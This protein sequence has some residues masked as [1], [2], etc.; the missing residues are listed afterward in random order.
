MTFDVKHVFILKSSSRNC[1]S[2]AN[3]NTNIVLGEGSSNLTKTLHLD[4]VLVVPSLNYNLLSVSQITNTNTGTV[5]LLLMVILTQFLV[6]G[7]PILLK[8]YTWIL[9]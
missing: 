1:V 6:K 4:S 2:T 8:L 3:S 7:P 5:F 9:Y